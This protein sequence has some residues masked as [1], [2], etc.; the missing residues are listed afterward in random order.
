MWVSSKQTF[1]QQLTTHT[2]MYNIN[3][4]Y[5][6]VNCM[7]FNCP[8]INDS[9]FIVFHGY[10]DLS[11]RKFNEPICLLTVSNRNLLCAF[12]LFLETMWPTYKVVCHYGTI[13]YWKIFLE[14]MKLAHCEKGNP[15]LMPVLT[16][17]SWHSHTLSIFW[18]ALFELWPTKYYDLF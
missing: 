11:T 1:F 6:F 7:Y 15:I 9:W 4:V 14:S 10:I 12:A 18:K 13:W 2:N 5:P 17:K 16:L 8:R 3:C